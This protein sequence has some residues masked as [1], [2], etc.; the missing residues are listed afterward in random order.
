[1]ENEIILNANLRVER[2]N[3]MFSLGL[4][5]SIDKIVELM[6]DDSALNL[7]VFELK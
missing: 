7:T 5:C 6:F 4:F 1:M 2:N 3:K